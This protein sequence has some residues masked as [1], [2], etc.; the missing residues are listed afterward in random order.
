MTFS[1]FLGK[2][3]K[4][5]TKEYRLFTI[6]SIFVPFNV[7]IRVSTRLN[8]QH[9]QVSRERAGGRTQYSKTYGRRKRLTS[10]SPTPPPPLTMLLPKVL[11]DIS[12]LLIQFP[13]AIAKETTSV[14]A[15]FYFSLFVPKRSSYR[16]V[17]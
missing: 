2:L 11:R 10:C 6:L 7:Y 15:V 12:Y 13:T 4:I 8:I 14:K 5:R 1:P 17:S 16:K 9:S 3:S